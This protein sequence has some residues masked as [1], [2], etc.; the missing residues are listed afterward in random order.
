MPHK[1]N[2]NRKRR[3]KIIIL[4]KDNDD[5]EFKINIFKK[6]KNR[7]QRKKKTPE[8]NKKDRKALT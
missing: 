7:L 2:N 3:R 1:N 8:E 6:I 4:R 5:A